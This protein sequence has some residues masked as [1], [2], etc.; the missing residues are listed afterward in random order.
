M[1]IKLFLTLTTIL[2]LAACRSQPAPGPPVRMSRYF[3]ETGHTVQGD[4]LRFFDVYGGINSFGL[5]LT[6]EFLVDGWRVQYF[7]KGRLEYHPENEPDYRVV[8]GWLGDLLRR[9]TPPLPPSHL[10]ATNDPYRRYFPETGHTLSG[11]FLTYFDTHGGSVRFGQPISEPF[12]EQGRIAQDLQ[13]ARFFW[14]PET[15]PPVTL[16]DIGRVHLDQ[17]R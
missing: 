13:S 11:D 8:V 10:P 12:L 6:E 16:E 3:P 5:P 15:A 14:T 4:F 17:I 9:R 1:K 2:I 7:E